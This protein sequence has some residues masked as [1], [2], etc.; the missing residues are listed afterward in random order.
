MT[1]RIFGLSNEPFLH[2]FAL[3]DAALAERGIRRYQVDSKPGFPDRIEL[4][5]LE[6]GETALLLNYTHQSADTPYRASHA[7]YIGE[8]PRA[9]AADTS[10]VPEALASRLISLR[11]FDAHHM[12][13]D[14][15]VMDG[16]ALP[17]GIAQLFSQP[18]VAYLHAHFARRG[19]FAA[20]I[21]R[22]E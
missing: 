16:T 13:V 20:R 8:N 4:R 2:L 19:C 22:Q 18:A 11:A 6:P 21:E 14:A 5:D 7:I 9:V 10:D 1:F 12:M 17:D 15:E 3:S